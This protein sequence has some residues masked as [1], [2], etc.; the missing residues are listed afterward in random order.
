MINN[1]AGRSPRP[2]LVSGG[3]GA[4]GLIACD[5]I[6]RCLESRAGS[7]QLDAMGLPSLKRPKGSDPTRHRT[8][9]PLHMRRMHFLF[10][11]YEYGL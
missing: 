4:K 3:G 8:F 5:E 1:G 7:R 10:R 11:Q 2:H 9:Y 6:G